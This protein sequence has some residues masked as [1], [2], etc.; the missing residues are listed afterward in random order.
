MQAMITLMTVMAGM[1]F[2]LCLALLLEELLFGCLFR[3]F[4]DT[5]KSA[6]VNPEPHC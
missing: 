2:S 6:G 5:A 4:F 1:F 3:L